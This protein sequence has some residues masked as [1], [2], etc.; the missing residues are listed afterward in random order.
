[1]KLIPHNLPTLNSEEIKAITKTIRSNWIA[2]GKETKRF[3][4]DFCRLIKGRPHHAAVV[5][6]G[7]AAM[8]VALRALGVEKGDEVV[9][10]SYVPG[11]LNSLLLAQAKP[12]LVD[13]DENDFNISFKETKKKITKLTK[14]IIV[15]H[16]FGVPVQIDDFLKLGI[17]IIEDCAHALGAKYKGKPVGTL[18][19]ASIFSFYASK[20][21]TTGQGGLIY[22]QDKKIMNRV[23]EI[24]DY[25]TPHGCDL[26]INLMMTDMQAAMGRV[27]IKKFPKFLKKRKMIADKYFKSFPA[28]IIWTSKKMKDRQ[29]VYYRFILRVSNQKEIID[30]LD[31]KGI[32][33][34]V[35][36]K[37]NE[38]V[39][40]SLGAKNSEFLVSEKVAKT[41]ISLPIYPS[42]TAK[43][44][45]YIIKSVKEVI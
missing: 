22:S 10:P 29:P 36:F 26:R 2:H 43:Q 42:L 33:T 13:I 39:H 40:R 28:D 17:P 5:S 4:D 20:P 15:P 25:D 44:V 1:M 38:L 12:V 21:I 3:E 37:P 34:I 11:V 30:Q 32:K 6:S 19:Q 27:Q 9:L 14:A 23:K 41:T 45:D 31:K 8:Y 24:L 7:G 35:P 16:I 18:A